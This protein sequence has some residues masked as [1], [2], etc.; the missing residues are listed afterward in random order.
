VR[1]LALVLFAVTAFGCGGS[2]SPSAPTPPPPPPPPPVI[3]VNGPSTLRNGRAEIFTASVSGCAWGTDAP[4]VVSISGSGEVRPSAVGSA[5]IWCDAQGARGTKTLGVIPD[6]QGTWVGDYTIES[7]TDSGWATDIR[8]CRDLTP[9]GRIAN[10]SF[11]LIQDADRVSGTVT[12]GSGGGTGQVQGAV[13]NNEV[14]L[15]GSV[16]SSVQTWATTWRFRSDRLDRITGSTAAVVRSSTGP[17]ELR[18]GGT[19]RALVR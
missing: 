7:C 11:N 19:I 18:L 8:A 13:V 10:V 12:L 2:S 16:P 1:R 5:T 3:T 17:G 15:T 14:T 9:P 6:F 4:S